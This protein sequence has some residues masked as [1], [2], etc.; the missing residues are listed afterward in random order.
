MGHG[1]SDRPQKA[2]AN[3]IKQNT[4]L[5]EPIQGASCYLGQE[6]YPPCPA[7]IERAPPGNRP[8]VSPGVFLFAPDLAKT[9]DVEPVM[10]QSHS[11]ELA[12]FGAGCFWG[13]EESFRQVPGVLE[14]TVGYLGGMTDKPTYKDVCTGRTGHAEVVQV[15]FEPSEVTYRQLVDLF[16]ELH[17]PTTRDRQGPDIGTQYRSAI[18]FHTAEQQQIA[19]EAKKR[20]DAS[21]KLRRP[22]VTEIAPA[23]TFYEAEDYHQKYLLKRGLGSCHI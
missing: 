16:F 19:Q 20:L 12:T 9:H 23:S 18:F 1:L 15:K 2:A 7:A 13:V 22:V 14:T 11:P 8:Q 10:N 17:D 5:R 4:R 21:G 3:E 6:A